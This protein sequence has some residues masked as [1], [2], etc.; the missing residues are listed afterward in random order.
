MPQS[1]S[2][3]RPIL[4][5]IKNSKIYAIRPEHQH[6]GRVLAHYID[7]QYSFVKTHYWHNRHIVTITH[8]YS[9]RDAGKGIAES[10][11][12]CQAGLVNYPDVTSGYTDVMAINKALRELESNMDIARLMLKRDWGPNK[13]GA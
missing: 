2:P 6:P 5:L 3:D 7:L 8:T 11:R 9:P 10:L 13:K 12:V 1:S 4:T